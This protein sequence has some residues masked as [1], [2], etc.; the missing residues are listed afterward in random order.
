MHALVP[1]VAERVSDVEHPIGPVRRRR[2]RRRPI[3]VARPLAFVVVAHGSRT[4]KP[5]HDLRSAEAAAADASWSRRARSTRSTEVVRASPGPCSTA[6]VAASGGGVGG[7]G[8]SAT[9][10]HRG[11]VTPRSTGAVASPSSSATRRPVSTR[12]PGSTDWVRDPAP[13]PRRESNV[14]MATTVLC[15]EALRQRAADRQPTTG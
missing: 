11:N 8:C 2:M 7:L 6:V 9:S 15:F 14:A 12:T 1:G 5:R 13:W 10:S 4:G 3:S